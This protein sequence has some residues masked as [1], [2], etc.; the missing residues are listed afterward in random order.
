MPAAPPS[1][2]PVIDLDVSTAGF[3]AAHGIRRMTVIN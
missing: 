1:R 2:F 3:D